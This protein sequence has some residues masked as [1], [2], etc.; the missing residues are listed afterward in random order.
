MR[1]SFW[2]KAAAAVT[3]MVT[4]AAGLP[5]QAAVGDAAYT[6]KVNKAIIQ[7]ATN[8]FVSYEEGLCISISAKY[9]AK[10]WQAYGTSTEEDPDF[11][12]LFAYDSEGNV[13]DIQHP[14]SITHYTRDASGIPTQIDVW[15]SA[16]DANGRPTA[17]AYEA[18]PETYQYTVAY[19]TDKRFSTASGNEDSYDFVNQY[20]VIYDAKGRITTLYSDLEGG[21]YKDVI[22]YTYDSKNRVK[23]YNELNDGRLQQSTKITYNRYG[24]PLKET[25]TVLT[26][27]ADGSLAGSGAGTIVYSF[28]QDGTLR[29]K[30]STFGTETVVNRY[31]Y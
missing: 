23:E 14:Y 27:D 4:L 31:V 2:K 20:Q 29:K 11:T 10:R 1:G 28:E 24:E 16:A 3:M 19:D 7:S 8:E 26:Y 18:E 21:A 30:T 22:L 13:Q 25:R 15:Y 9:F 12:D 17:G 6:S 5:V